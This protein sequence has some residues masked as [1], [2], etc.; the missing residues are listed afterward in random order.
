[1]SHERRM[2]ILQ[3]IVEDYVRTGEPIGSKTL[4]QR[5]HLQVSSATIRN[6]MAA[7]E[8]QGLLSAPHASAGRIPTEQGYRFFVDT[9]AAPRALSAT[10]VSALR[11]ILES[12][13]SVED[14]IEAATRTL[15]HLT[16]QVAL[17][18]YPTRNAGTLLHLEF[19]PLDSRTLLALLISDLGTI[20]RVTVILPETTALSHDETVSA[21]AAIKENLL[22]ML[23]GLPFENISAL[24]PEAHHPA[25]RGRSPELTEAIVDHLRAQPYFERDIRFAIS[26]TSNL[27]RSHDDFS[28]S[29]A[30]IL[31]ALEEQVT[32]LR[33][34]SHASVQEAGYSV[35]IGHENTEQALQ[36]ASIVTGEYDSPVVVSYGKQ[37]LPDNEGALGKHTAKLGVVGPV[38]MDYR[39]N[40]AAVNAVARYLGHVLG[41]R[42]S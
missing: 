30:P 18:Q 37:H 42:A 4:A 6:D 29:I 31:D 34:L 40:I 36:G 28:A 1:M 25:L 7:L 17:I 16:H 11:Q 38:R 5:H 39:G 3:A 20:H 10:Q 9:L 35:R 8:E 41:T 23:Q 21:L 24:L 12:A 2:R 33:V 26:G 27:A 15:A 13:H 32:L 14:M 22:K 19:V